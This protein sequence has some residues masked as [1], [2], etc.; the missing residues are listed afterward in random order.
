[1]ASK[2]QICNLAISHIGVGKEI[3]NV[4]TDKG[5]EASACRRYYETCRD[6]ALRD[7]PW[8]FATVVES[9]ALIEEDPNDE[10]AYSYRYPTD[11]ILFR[12]ILSGI[13][14]DSRQTRV[15]FRIINDSS[16]RLIYCDAEDAVAEYTK[17]E[18]NPDLYTPDFY[19]ALSFLIAAHIAPR[20]TAGDPFKLGDR[21]ARMYEIQISRA[22]AMA[23]N[24]EQVEEDPE[25]EFIRGRE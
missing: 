21:A 15:P 7:F 4:D 22:K 16:G 18:T 23:K 13:R 3:A 2:T 11:C 24:E 14:N 9:L 19:L 17:K 20:L 1:M 6:V 10:W 5:D 25:S 12:R 8:P